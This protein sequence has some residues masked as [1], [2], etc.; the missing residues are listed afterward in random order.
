MVVKTSTEY[1]QVA[2]KSVNYQMSAWTAMAS[3]VDTFTFLAHSHP[4]QLQQAQE[5]P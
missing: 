3:G 1:S 5:D 4:K 2:Y